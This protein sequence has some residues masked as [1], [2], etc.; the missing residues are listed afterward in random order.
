MTRKFYLLSIL[1]LIF[2]SCTKII[3]LYFGAHNPHEETKESISKFIHKNELDI[4]PLLMVSMDSMV[5]CLLNDLGKTYIFDRNGYSIDY[6]SSFANQKC[7]GNILKLIPALTETTYYP[8]DS[9]KTFSVEILKW[10]YINSEE[11]FVDNTDSE[12]DYTV[13]Y[14]WNLFCG[15]PN[16]KIM[17]KDLVQAVNSNN[18]VKIRL[19]FVNQDIREGSGIKFK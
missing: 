17:M 3:N 5:T 19:I 10:V 2:S 1:L 7:S 16:N 9:S 15:R 14:Y 11:P 18:Q 4:P 8:R 6:N 13:I 12:I